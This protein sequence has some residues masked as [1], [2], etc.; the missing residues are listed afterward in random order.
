MQY[1]SVFPKLSYNTVLRYRT[2]PYIS[3]KN[4]PYNIVHFSVKCRTFIKKKMYNFVHK[5]KSSKTDLASWQPWCKELEKLGRQSSLDR[6]LK[7][8]REKRRHVEIQEVQLEDDEV[9]IIKYQHILHD[10]LADF[11]KYFGRFSFNF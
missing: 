7:S 9:P 8:K 6:E 11:P 2:I 1:I 4:T 10:I 3:L 5:E